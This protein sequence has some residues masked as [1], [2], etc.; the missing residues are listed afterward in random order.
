MTVRIMHNRIKR[1]KVVMY[2]TFF[3][4]FLVWY[5]FTSPSSL[6]YVRELQN[7]EL[8]T[9]TNKFI[10]DTN[11]QRNENTSILEECKGMNESFRPLLIEN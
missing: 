4:T 9:C 7:E 10:V 11:V 5:I 1:S 3:A 6:E 2:V 8:T